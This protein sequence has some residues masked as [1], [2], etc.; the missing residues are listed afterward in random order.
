M[1]YITGEVILPIVTVNNAHH[2][3]GIEH[4]TQVEIKH[5]KYGPHR[6]SNSSDEVADSNSP[7]NPHHHDNAVSSDAST[8]PARKNSTHLRVCY[9]LMIRFFCRFTNYNWKSLYYMVGNFV[10]FMGLLIH[11]EL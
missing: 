11:T 4:M 7:S 10:D 3:T 1:V 9:I 8:P 2:N 5:S 6:F